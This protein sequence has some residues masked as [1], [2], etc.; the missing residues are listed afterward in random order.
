MFEELS[1]INVSDKVENKNGLS[2]LRN[3][4]NGQFKKK[5]GMRNTKIYNA[6][7]GMKSRCY[8]ANNKSYK[9]YGNRGI[10]VCEK[11]KN[12]FNEFYNWSIYNGY[13]ENLTI[14][15][16]DNNG[17]YE[18]SNCRW[19]TTKE[20]NRNYSKNRFYYIDNKKYCIAEISEKY[21]I[22]YR[23]LLYRLNNNYTLEEAIKGVK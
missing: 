5:H 7:C 15:R 23:T 10:K 13:K 22:N 1:N 20:Q 3:D 2:Y 14:D 11:W 6:W 12:D 19:V 21:N 8:N 18:P 17:N 16:I 9:N 4:K